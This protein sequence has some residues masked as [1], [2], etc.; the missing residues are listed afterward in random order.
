MR[1]RWPPYIV[2][3][4]SLRPPDQRGCPRSTLVLPSAQGGWRS[5]GTFAARPGDLSPSIQGAGGCVDIHKQP[6]RL[7][8]LGVAAPGCGKLVARAIQPRPGQRVGRPEAGGLFPSRSTRL[9]PSREARRAAAPPSAAPAAKSCLGEGGSGHSGPPASSPRHPSQLGCRCVASGAGGSSGVVL[10]SRGS[11][12]APLTAERSPDT[13]THN[14]RG[15]FREAPS[16]GAQGVSFVSEQE[17][18]LDKLGVTGSNPAPPTGNPGPGA[19]VLSICVRK[20]GGPP[21]RAADA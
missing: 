21:K 8:N 1:S 14:A 2:S 6:G 17:P 11:G 16:D 18:R 4:S 3:T 12:P 5:P 15:S 13:P 9:W 19:A 20:D 10:A 7:G